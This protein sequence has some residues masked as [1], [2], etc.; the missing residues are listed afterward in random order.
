MSF[1]ALTGDMDAAVMSSLGDG[2]AN[3]FNSAGAPVVF[4]LEVIV[5]HGLERAGAE[6]RFRT[7][8]IGVTWRKSCLSDVECGGFFVH[9]SKRL[10]V[11]VVIFDDGHMIT[12]ACMVTP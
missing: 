5:D 3:Y 11:E 1:A 10:T 7:D 4:D 8:A 9:E 12:A 6:G 2:L